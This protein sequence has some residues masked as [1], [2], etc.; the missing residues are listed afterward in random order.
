MFRPLVALVATLA[1]L[2]ASAALADSIELS[3]QARLTTT[4]GGPVADGAYSFSIALYDEPSGG[5]TLWKDFFLGVQVSSGLLSVNLGSG[6]SKLDSAVFGGPK[7]LYVGITVA[8]EPELPRV[9]LR[10]VPYAA[11]AHLTAMASDLQCSGCVGSA[12]LVKGAVTGDKI[13]NGAVGANHVSFNWAASDVAGG[14]ASFAQ[15]ANT[16]KIAD[17]AK[18]AT[19]ASYADEAGSAKVAKTLQCTGCVGLGALAADIANGFLSVK[20]GAVSG[21]LE[22][23]GTLTAKA[24]L[25]VAG[26][27]ALNDSKITGGGFAAVDVK[28]QTCNAKA[29]GRIVLDTTSSRLYFCDGKAYLRLT[30]CSEFCPSAD[31][32]T[33]GE[34]ILDGCGGTGCS[35]KGSKCPVGAACT[36][37]KC[38]S[39]LGTQGA[40]AVNC[41]AILAADANS[42]TGSYWLDP[43]GA[44]SGAAVQGWCEMKAHGGGWTLVASNAKSANVLP[45]N[46]QGVVL[47]DPGYSTASPTG[48]YVFGPQMTKLVFTEALVI[49]VLGAKSVAIKHDATTY[50]YVSPK[51]NDYTVLVDE[52]GNGTCPANSKYFVLGCEEK[53]A[54]NDANSNQ[55]TTGVC[56]VSDP[57]G[58]PS[59]GTNFGHGSSEGSWEGYYQG[60][61]CGS[62]VDVDQYTSWVR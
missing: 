8:G 43:D 24:T 31:Q 40:P 50:P 19:T 25:N 55:N 15:G 53:D 36:G 59:S 60:N 29:A 62:A 22:V 39:T 18:Q 61:P 16:A 7:P 21:D 2:A 23:G 9:Q 34:P 26:E 42:P 51:A 37:G 13:A 44:G 56:I 57:S 12:D 45:S 41:K 5:V 49:A 14:P 38:L 54:G 11:F 20:G 33:C 35:G 17:V 4:G 58:D 32:V 10:R 30:V 1:S 3:A 47:T 27:L 46:G 48:D 6:D 52:V 28:T